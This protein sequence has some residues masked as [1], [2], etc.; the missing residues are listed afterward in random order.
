MKIFTKIAIAAACV[1]TA[2]NVSAQGR[3]DLLWVLGDATPSGWSTDDA[4]ALLAPA[5]DSKIYSGTM[6]LEADKDFKFLTT[7]DFGNM[8]YRAAT[9]DATPDADGKVALVLTGDGDDFKIH[10][11]E[12]ANY[13]ITVDTESLEATIV[14]SAYQETQV[15]YASIFIVGSAL[16]TGYAV[17][18][19]LAMLQNPAAPYEFSVSNASMQEGSFKI[20]TALKGSGTWDARYWYF[21]DPADPTKMMPNADGDNQW[22]ISTAGNYDVKAN[23]ATNVISIT[24]AGQSGISEI[25]AGAVEDLPVAYYTIEGRRVDAPVAGSLVIKVSADGTATKVRF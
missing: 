25:T 15:R 1:V 4:T 3:T 2:A 6:Y 12:S 19:G 21:A 7:Y 17:D 16:S 18:K 8:E 10:V 23:L 22:S 20:A 11:T 13:L 24:E 9:A 5:D 14:K